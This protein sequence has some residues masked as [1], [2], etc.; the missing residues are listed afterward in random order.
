MCCIWGFGAV[1]M[2]AHRHVHWIWVD[3]TLRQLNTST[4]RAFCLGRVYGR[5]GGGE[6]GSGVTAVL[7]HVC[8]IRTAGGGRKNNKLQLPQRE[9]R[10]GKYWEIQTTE[11]FKHYIF[12][13]TKYFSHICVLEL[14]LSWRSRFIC[15]QRYSWR[16]VLE[17][18]STHAAFP[19]Y[20][21]SILKW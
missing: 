10:L 20:F 6:A 13:T 15:V 16:F 14:Q 8:V 3:T 21:S 4:H 18:H 17:V 7:G 19:S 9:E 11:F 5:W 12:S 1:W 2:V